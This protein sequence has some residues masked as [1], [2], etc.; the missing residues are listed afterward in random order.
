M[1]GNKPDI[2][3][4]KN[5]I[6]NMV[7]Q[8]KKRDEIVNFLLDKVQNLNKL[9]S[10]LQQTSSN[11]HMPSSVNMTDSSHTVIEEN[12]EL[13]NDNEV[14]QENISDLMEHIDEV[15][16]STILQQEELTQ[17]DLPENGRNERL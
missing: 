10:S 11:F 15:L 14:Q 3:S 2:T 16:P 1:L 5:T 17:D 7:Q 8:N 9:V 4:F 6:N 13:T 12:I